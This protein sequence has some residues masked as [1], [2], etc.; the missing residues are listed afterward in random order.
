MVLTPVLK[1]RSVDRIT[2]SAML[3][4]A[5]NSRAGKL[6]DLLS[7]LYS[8]YSSKFLCLVRGPAGAATDPVDMG[9]AV[10][11][12]VQSKW[13]D[14]RCDDRACTLQ[15]IT[16][17]AEFTHVPNEYELVAIGRPFG[18][19]WVIVSLLTVQVLPAPPSSSLHNVDRQSRRRGVRYAGPER[20]TRDGVGTFPFAWCSRRENRGTRI[21]HDVCIRGSGHPRLRAFRA[22]LDRHSRLLVP[23]RGCRSEAAVRLWPADGCV[24]SWY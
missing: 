17:A 19:H 5:E 23:G 18:L 8:T 24:A 10:A 13:R 20:S 6:I 2:R 16:S 11:M 9:P 12:A 7:C 14:V 4:G 22:I 21:G 1:T 15:F 3:R